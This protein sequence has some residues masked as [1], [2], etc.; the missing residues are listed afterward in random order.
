MSLDN[1]GKRNQ[2]EVETG[3]KSTLQALEQYLKSVP[4]GSSSQE[5]PEIKG[6]LEV[7]PIFAV[8]LPEQ[9]G[10]TPE[11]LAQDF[12]ATV[13]FW[14]QSKDDPAKQAEIDKRF[15][16][17][18]QN[19]EAAS[20]EA[21]EKG[22]MQAVRLLLLEV[23]QLSKE[24]G[25]APFCRFSENGSVE[26]HH[27]QF[28]EKGPPKDLTPP[29]KFEMP[30]LKIDG[31]VAKN[32]DALVDKYGA[33]L[34]KEEKAALRKGL[35]AFVTGDVEQ[36][37]PM[38]EGAPG[39]SEKVAKAFKECLEADN[40]RHVVAKRGPDGQ[41]QLEILDAGQRGIRISYGTSENDKSGTVV[42]E[43][44][45]NKQSWSITIDT[46]KDELW[47]QSPSSS[48]KQAFGTN[49]RAGVKCIAEVEEKMNDALWGTIGVAS[50]YKRRLANE[51]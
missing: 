49:S 47:F 40:A 11:Q 45:V 26:I 14:K 21:Y 38:I 39:H 16:A 2:S 50:L 22:G 36:L 24:N 27:G 48:K 42:L 18:S 9:A 29:Y 31:V 51:P 7:P 32:L 6:F 13:K 4:V 28:F 5:R 10:K 37:V 44:L 25:F 41:R 19:I 15:M 33:T 43:A 23:N 3:S 17:V 20:K 46:S 35:L 8:A 1:V 30:G 34:N 12:D